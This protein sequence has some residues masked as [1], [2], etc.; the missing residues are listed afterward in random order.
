MPSRVDEAR[1]EG[2]PFFL[3]LNPTRMHVFTHLSPKY[4]A[5]RNSKNGW[6]IEE[7]GMAQLD[8]IVGSV[9]KYV[10]DNGLDGDTIVAFSTDNGAEN[11]SWPDGGRDSFFAGG[12]GTALEGGFPRSLHY[13]LARACTSR[14]SGKRHRIRDG[15][16]PDIRCGCGKSE[17]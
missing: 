12:K 1:K 6:T 10:Q 3:W 15:L 4:E 8:D 11:F 7:A 16:V 17:Y 9:M 2:K 5:M 13:S 14:K